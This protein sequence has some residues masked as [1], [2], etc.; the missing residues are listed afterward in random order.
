MKPANWIFKTFRSIS[1]AALH[2]YRF[3]L[4]GSVVII[5]ELSADSFCSSITSCLAEEL[6]SERNLLEDVKSADSEDR[7]DECGVT[8][9]EEVEVLV[10]ELNDDLDSASEVLLLEDIAVPLEQ[11][12]L[13]LLRLASSLDLPCR[14]KLAASLTSPCGTHRALIKPF[15]SSSYHLF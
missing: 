11:D 3:F 14:L 15:R 5:I 6:R 1:F 12:G 2:T 9:G 8:H 10:C 7:H 13:L 4:T